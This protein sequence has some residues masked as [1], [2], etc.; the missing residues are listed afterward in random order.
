MVKR[1][2]L[3]GALWLQVGALLFCG[4][5]AYAKTA[6]PDSTSDSSAMTELR[7]VK[8]IQISPLPEELPNRV[9]KGANIVS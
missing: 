6:P 3:S 5:P 7:N 9:L 8:Y 4:V 2:I 1:I